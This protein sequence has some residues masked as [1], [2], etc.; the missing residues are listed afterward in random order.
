MLYTQLWQSFIQD[1]AFSTEKSQKSPDFVRKAKHVKKARNSKS[2]VKKLS[3]LP[4]GKTSI[5]VNWIKPFNIFAM[6][7][8]RNK[9]QQ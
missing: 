5:I 4:C 8:L 2:G 9:N 6:L 3:W 1:Q 7:L